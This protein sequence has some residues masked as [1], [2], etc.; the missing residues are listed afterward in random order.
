MQAILEKLWNHTKQKRR[1]LLLKQYEKNFIKAKLEIVQGA[2]GNL[3]ALS[4]KLIF[5]NNNLE[6]YYHKQLTDISKTV[7]DILIYLKN[8]P[9]TIRSS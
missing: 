2:N 4:D 8:Q 7:N 6:E 5:V 3:E 9:W 1:L